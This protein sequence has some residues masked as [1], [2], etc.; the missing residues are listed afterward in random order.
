MS[1]IPHAAPAQ[2]DRPEFQ[3][4]PT[5]AVPL[6]IC[7]LP[8]P[9]PLNRELKTLFASVEAQGDTYANPEPFVA[10]NKELYESNFTLF[11][12]PQ[13]C[14][15]KLREFCLRSLYRAIGELN[16]YDTAMLQRLHIATE[17]WFHTARKGGYFGAHNHPLHSWSGVYCVQHDGDDPDTDSGK[18]TFINPLSMATTY[19]DMAVANL[20][21]PYSYAMRK[22]RLVPGQLVLFPSWLLHEVMPYDG[23]TQRI[24]VAFNARFK[25]AGAQ[26]AQVPRL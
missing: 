6:V 26:P 16:G 5:F 7:H 2:G 3:I 9:E 13:A 12:W 15:Q 22:D 4:V 19:T 1:D 14:V 11:D 23:D 25:L 18:L 24:T 20:K 17:S 8:D 10:R 21:M